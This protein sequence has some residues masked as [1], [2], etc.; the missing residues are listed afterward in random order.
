MNV[1][2]GR[3]LSAEAVGRL[4]EASL[5]GVREAARYAVSFLCGLLYARGVVFSRCA[6][7]GAAAVA[8]CPYR[9]LLS[10]LLG[11][12]AGALL[13][14][15][16]QTPARYLAAVLA[17]AAIRW[18]VNDVARLRSH[19]AFAPVTALLP[20][21]STG[22]AMAFVNGSPTSTVAVYFAESVL[23]AGAAYF[24]ARSVEAAGRAASGK[25]LSGTEAASLAL[26]GGLLLLPLADLTLGP[27]SFGRVLASLLV[28]LASRSAGAAGGAVAGVAAGVLFGLSTAGLTYL[29]GAYA[30]GGLMAGLFS[31]LGRLCSAAVF[32][33]SGAVASLQVGNQQAV[34]AG[35]L[36]SAAAAAIFLALPARLGGQIS[37]LF[38]HKE[39]AAKSDALRRTVVMKL[40]Y[41]AK[42]LGGV[43]ETVEEVS[44]KLSFTGAPDI[45]AL[46]RRQAEDACAGCGLRIYCWSQ[47]YGDTM[48]ALNALTPALRANGRAVRGDLPEHF[49]AHCARVNELINGINREY[50]AFAAREAAEQRLAQIR[51][52]VAGQ[53]GTVSRMLEDMAGELE[54][55][56]RFDFAAARR[57]GEALRAMGLLPLDVSCRVDRFGRMT[58]EAEA[59]RG[60]KT[61]LSRSELTREVSRACGKPFSPPCVSTAQG[62]CRI[63]MSE[64]PVFR[65]ETG[66]SQHI[67]GNG[68]LC[69]DSFSCFEDGC[70]RQA[71]VLS[72][73]MGAGGRA[74]V[75]GAMASGLFSRLLQAGVGP[76]AAL[77]V[78]NSALIAKSGDES[79]ATL[80]LVQLDLFSG[81]ACFYKA[82]AALS[83]VRHNGRAAAVDAPSLPV[84][85]LN[86]SSFARRTGSLGDGDLV[87]L[88]SDGA[89]SSGEEWILQEVES[90]SGSN[91]QELAES[92]V[93]GAVSRRS[94]GHDD[95]V[96]VLELQIKAPRR[97]FPEEEAS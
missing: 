57:V 36:E 89:L 15:Q 75:D 46:Y 31:P 17:A 91:P 33:L 74:A 65:V 51:S 10:T 2:K 66:F 30:L 6:P 44:R 82:G 49:A 20:L 35:L 92:L 55:Y 32:T 1:A 3:K 86:E 42:A 79:L 93:C 69:G 90:F 87:V 13:P 58:V 56:E 40:D 95:D 41:A 5:P 72:D 22:L 38:Q 18:T 26:A 60:E 63:Q 8:A 16:A 68:R 29:S 61:R 85:I 97:S 50:A 83:I 24:A 23:G 21:V 53:F 7:F 73:G 59:A 48:D 81:E 96:T 52:L 76:E 11:A 39:D 12:L 54:L 43:S 80:D 47:H 27:V 37:G 77:Q 34:L 4:A 45:S 19:P 62:K 67:F 70:G 94:D 78:V 88:M 84:G 28:L 64:K 71:A 14:G 9:Y 25:P